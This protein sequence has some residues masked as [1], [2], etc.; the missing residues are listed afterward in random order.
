MFHKIET[1]SLKRLKPCPL[2]ISTITFTG[3][4]SISELS[5]VDVHLFMEMSDCDTVSVKKAKAGKKRLVSGEPTTFYN[6]LELMV[7]RKAVKI[8]K[9]GSVH[10]TGCRSH[11]ELVST[12]EIVCE[13]LQDALAIPVSLI[14]YSIQMLNVNFS[15]G[16]TLDLRKLQERFLDIT[17]FASFEPDSYPG[18]NVKLMFDNNV[19]CSCLLFHSGSVA[20]AGAK[21]PHAI[22]KAYSTICTLIDECE[23]GTFPVENFIAP[24][25]RSKYQSLSFVD[26]YPS[27]S[28]FLCAR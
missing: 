4:L 28:Y 11:Y 8:F 16:H 22:Y 17:D 9:N 10:V 6:N 21:S 27:G 24:A 25:G 15:L 18:L 23:D 2:V 13:V 20:L 26:G 7:E 12:L 19:K 14:E 3:K 5:L 1:L